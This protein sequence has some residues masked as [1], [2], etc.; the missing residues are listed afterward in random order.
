MPVKVKHSERELLDRLPIPAASPT[1]FD[2]AR[3][4]QEILEQW[5]NP[6]VKDAMD[7]AVLDSVLTVSGQ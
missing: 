5:N 4:A 2:G 6:S 1:A 7:K 3:R